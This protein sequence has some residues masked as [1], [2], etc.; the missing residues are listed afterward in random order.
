MQEGE[1]A[2][3]ETGAV[4]VEEVAVLPVRLEVCGFGEGEFGFLGGAVGIPSSFDGDEGDVEDG[5]ELV[6]R[7]QGELVG[8]F[9]FETRVREKKGESG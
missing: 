9:A 5:V 2:A 6:D 1:E 7:V 4:G 8:V 3:G